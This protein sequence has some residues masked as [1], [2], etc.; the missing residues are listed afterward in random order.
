MIKTRV[1]FLLL[2]RVFAYWMKWKWSTGVNYGD[3]SRK[4]S[5]GEIQVKVSVGTA[6]IHKSEA[7]ERFAC[8]TT[9]DLF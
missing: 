2:A 6:T 1:Q 3:V 8:L 5:A 7:F 4:L 9:L